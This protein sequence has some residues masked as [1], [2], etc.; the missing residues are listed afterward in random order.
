MVRENREGSS[1]QEVSE[2]DYS[3]VDSKEFSI[4]G[5]IIPFSFVELPAEKG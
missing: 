4:S 2:M 5:G 3:R 1:L